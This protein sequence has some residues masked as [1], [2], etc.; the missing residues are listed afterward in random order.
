M[1]HDP[2]NAAKPVFEF[3]SDVSCQMSGD[4]VEFIVGG[5]LGRFDVRR[6]LSTL[7]MPILIV[8]GRF[9]RAVPPRL[10]AEYKHF[11]PNAQ[12]AIFEASGH[13]PFVEETSKFIEA[14]KTVVRK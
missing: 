2:A 5:D 9:D 12:F 4:D 10:A 14:L 8:T 13:A 6:A 11:L 3:N 7:R 1:F